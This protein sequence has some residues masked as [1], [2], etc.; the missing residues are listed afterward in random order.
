MEVPELQIDDVDSLKDLFQKRFT[1][2]VRHTETGQTL[3]L[4][5]QGFESLEGSPIEEIEGVYEHNKST[6]E[7]SKLYYVGKLVCQPDTD[8]CLVLY[9]PLYETDDLMVQAR[10][11]D[12]FMETIVRDGEEVYRFSRLTPA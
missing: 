8:E 6:P 2:T 11:I 12:M 1:G 9:I 3:V 10:P 5:E 7:D 4:R